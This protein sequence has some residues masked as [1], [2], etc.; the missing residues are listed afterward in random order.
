MLSRTMVDM[1]SRGRRRVAR[2]AAAPAG[3]HEVVVDVDLVGGPSGVEVEGRP[4]DEPD[5]AHL[6][7][8][9]AAHALVAVRR[10]TG[11]PIPEDVRRLAAEK[12]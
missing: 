2:D 3:R 10:R 11:R 5:Q 4:A 6:A 12:V 8:V 9:S 7:R 1:G